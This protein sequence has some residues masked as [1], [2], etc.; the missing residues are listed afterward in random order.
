MFFQH[1][2]S[3]KFHTYQACTKMNQNKTNPNFFDRLMKD[4][5]LG[6]MEHT[7]S[8]QSILLLG[9][10]AIIAGITILIFKKLLK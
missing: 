6:V 5:A 2:T 10:V 1:P 7:V 4:G 3:T 9:G 8:T